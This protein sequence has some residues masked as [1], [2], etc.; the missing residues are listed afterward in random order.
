MRPLQLLIKPSSANCNLNCKYCF[1]CDEGNKRETFSYG[2]MNEETLEVLVKKAFDYADGYCGFAFQGGEPTLVGLPFFE[3]LMELERRYNTKNIP[4][5]NSI[6]TNG[7]RL[8]EEWGEFFRRENFLVGLS[9]DGIKSTHDAYRVNKKGEGSFGEIMKTAEMFNRLGV[10]YNI[11]TVVNGK[12]GLR[13]AKIY[14][15]YKKN[16]FGYLQFIACLD[17]VGEEPGKRDYSLTPEIYGRFLIDLFDRWYEDVKT[18]TQ[19][20]IRQFENV[21][22]MVAGCEPESCEQR[23]ICSVQNVIEADGSVYP[24]DFYALDEYR[25]GNV[26]T[27][28]F[29]ELRSNPVTERFVRDSAESLEDCRNCRFFAICRGGCRRNRVTLAGGERKNYFCPAYRMFYEAT[30]ERFRELAGRYFTR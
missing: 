8:S 23:G 5:D 7:Y 29:Y 15:F 28:D 4:V 2:F 13:A 17:P 21:V 11:L 30:I 18:G 25:L 3:R 24:C 16:G 14:D 12:T 9:L 22:G 19:P 20:Y 27:H 6:Q 1:Y 26:H 10:E